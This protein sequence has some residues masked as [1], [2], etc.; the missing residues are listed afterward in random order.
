MSHRTHLSADDIA[1]AS[2]GCGQV[3]ISEVMWQVVDEQ[4]SASWAFLWTSTT[5]SVTVAVASST[6]V[7]AVRVAAHC[8]KTPLTEPVTASRCSFVDMY[9]VYSVCQQL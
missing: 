1:K 6:L 8:T 4:I 7:T 5:V 2:E 3:S 9:M